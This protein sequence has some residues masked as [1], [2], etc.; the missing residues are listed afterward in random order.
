MYV[1]PNSYL[2]RAGLSDV[3]ELIRG[4]L[5]ERS[6]VFLMESFKHPAE[7]QVLILFQ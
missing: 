5:G 4:T 6:T 7:P 2:T 1:F 3:K